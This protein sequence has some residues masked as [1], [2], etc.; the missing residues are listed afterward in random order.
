MEK[1]DTRKLAAAIEAF[2]TAL[3]D[4]WWS[5]GTCS[6]SRDMSCGPDL[7]GCDADLLAQKQF[8]EG[9]HVEMEMPLNEAIRHLMHKAIA[10]RNAARKVSTKNGTNEKTVGHRAGC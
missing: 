1:T 4:W 7:N 2:E 5:V 6:F 10:A 9:F 3:P 8:D